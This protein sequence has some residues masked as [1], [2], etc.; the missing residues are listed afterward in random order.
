MGEMADL[1]KDEFWKALNGM[2][3][4]MRE[5]NEQSIARDKRLA[6]RQEALAQSVELLMHE[7]NSVN[8]AIQKD[9]ENIRTLARIAEMHERRLTSLEGGENP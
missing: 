2:R 9:A 1:D 5:A 7:V 3:E 6:E 8:S 4:A